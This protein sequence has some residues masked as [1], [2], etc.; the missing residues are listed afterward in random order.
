[1]FDDEVRLEQSHTID[2]VED[3][4]IWRITHRWEIFF[5]FLI[6]DSLSKAFWFSFIGLRKWKPRKKIPGISVF[7][8]VSRTIHGK[9][10]SIYLFY[11]QNSYFS[12]TKKCHLFL[13]RLLYNHLNSLPFF[14][15]SLWSNNPSRKPLRLSL[16]ENNKGFVFFLHKSRVLSQHN[17]RPP[18]TIFINRSQRNQLEII[19]GRSGTKRKENNPTSWSVHLK[20]HYRHVVP[21]IDVGVKLKQTQELMIPLLEIKRR[22]NLSRRIMTLSTALFVLLHREKWNFLKSIFTAGFR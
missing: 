4:I 18:K 8:I 15:I 3:F 19:T 13:Y 9:Y 21:Y 5:L 16:Q 20:K 7:Q 11:V 17:P 12:Y 1:M 6:F 14:K 2:R 22:I 10:N